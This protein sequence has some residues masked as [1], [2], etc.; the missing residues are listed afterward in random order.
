MAGY[1]IFNSKEEAMNY[2][3]QAGMEAGLAYHKGQANGTRYM[4]SVIEHPTD[5]RGAC[6]V[7]KP[8]QVDENGLVI[9]PLPQKEDLQA[10]GWFPESEQTLE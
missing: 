6:Y 2:S 3:D 8:D 5:G 10:D 7:D 4:Y 9:D 1:V